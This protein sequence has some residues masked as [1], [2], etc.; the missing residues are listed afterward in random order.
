MSERWWKRWPGRY[1]YELREL[2]RAGF[3]IRHDRQAYRSGVARIEVRGLIAAAERTVNLTFPDLY[4]YFR[5]EVEAPAEA[6]PYHQHPGSKNLCVLGRS[7]YNW[8]PTCTAAWLLRE[9]V[10]K[11]FEAALAEDRTGLGALE[12][13]QGEPFGDYYRYAPSM[14]MIDSRWRVP[15][16]HVG[17]TFKVATV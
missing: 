14:I 17:G 6:L 9:Q 5:C 1:K 8:H 4:P 13:A 10:P 16:G 7:T 11:V 15:E 2:K 3:R 12:E